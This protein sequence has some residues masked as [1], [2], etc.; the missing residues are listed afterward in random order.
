VQGNL[1]STVL[2]ADRETIRKS[3][4]EVLAGAGSRP[5]HIFN[6]GHGVLPGTPVDN[7]IFLVDTVHA[8]SSRR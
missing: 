2:F 6:L 5:G 8:L 3:A 4:Q 1:D 7:V